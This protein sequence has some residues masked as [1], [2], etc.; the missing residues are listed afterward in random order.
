MSPDMIDEDELASVA[1]QLAVRVR[2]DPPA[3]N[4]RWL[5][6]MIP[7]GVDPA[8]WYL[9]LAVAAAA[10]V[11]TACPHCHRELTWRELTAWMRHAPVD[12]VTQRRLVLLGGDPD[13]VALAVAGGDPGRALTRNERVAVVSALHADGF[14]TAEIAT[15]A[16]CVKATVRRIVAAI[17]AAEG[18]SHG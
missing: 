12:V 15:R 7:D 4:G 1:A 10:A 5:A 13:V 18:V 3:A 11:P 14:S 8:W 6:A 16:R 17:Q 2:E 9:A